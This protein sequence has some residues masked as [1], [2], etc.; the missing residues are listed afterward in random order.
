VDV[1]LESESE[2]SQLAIIPDSASE[3]ESEL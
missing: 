2:A 3:S 1:E